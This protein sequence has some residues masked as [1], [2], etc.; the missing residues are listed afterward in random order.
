MVFTSAISKN[1]SFVKIQVYSC[2]DKFV[3]AQPIAIN[4][5]SYN[6]KF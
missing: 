4:K 5:I 1:F 3:L 2:I 6:E